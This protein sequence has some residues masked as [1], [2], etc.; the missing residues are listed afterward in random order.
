MD[1]VGVDEGDGE[2]SGG[3]VDGEVDGWDYVAL[4]GVGYEDGVGVLVDGRHCC[5]L[6]VAEAEDSGRGVS[7]ELYFRGN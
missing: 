7:E 2:A 4:E 5:E 1:V 6:R 3:K